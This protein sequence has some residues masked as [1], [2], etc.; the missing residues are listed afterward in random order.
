M[1]EHGDDNGS[2]SGN[3]D[4]LQALASR[5]VDLWQRQL[6]IMAA[7]PALSETMAAYAKFGAQAPDAGGSADENG[8]AHDSSGDTATTGDPAGTAPAH[9]AFGQRSSELDELSRRIAACEKRLAQME[10]ATGA[11]GGDA[12]KCPG[13]AES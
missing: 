6:E 2:S 8:T 10:Q 12:R 5:F 11:A 9:A 4:E 3:G 7:D 1:N 13:K